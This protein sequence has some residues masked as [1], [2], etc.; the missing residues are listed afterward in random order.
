MADDV[1]PALLEAIQKDWDHLLDTDTELQKLLSRIQSSVTSYR[2]AHRYAIM[3]GQ[4]LVTAVGYHVNPDTMPE[5]YFDVAQKVLAPLLTITHQRVS[6]VCKVI[7]DKINWQYHIGIKSQSSDLNTS[8][9]QH[10]CQKV[11]SDKLDK[12]IW[13]LQ[14][15]L[16]NFAQSVVDDTVEKNALVQANAGMQPKIIRTAMPGC[17]EWCDNLAGTY[18]YN[19]HTIDK[20]IF[21]RHQH[22]RCFVD[23]YPGDGMVQNSWSKKWTTPDLLKRKMKKREQEVL[24]IEAQKAAE[25][26]AKLRAEGRI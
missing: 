1:A 18:S 19:P 15:P 17:C 24:Q 11:S 25:R 12:T 10:L 9:I 13:L 7:Q 4:H 2:E 26:K 3:L 20:N 22:C 16:I 14:E 5:F 8:R 21:R 6:G 23:Y